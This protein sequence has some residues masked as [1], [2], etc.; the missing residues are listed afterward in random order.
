MAEEKI[1]QEEIL[2]DEQL[3]NISGGTYTEAEKDARTFA[4]AT[5]GIDCYLDESKT[6]PSIPKLKEAFETFGITLNYSVSGNNSYFFEGIKVSRDTAQNI[7]FATY[8]HQPFKVDKNG[9]MTY[10]K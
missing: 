7:I 1:F 5:F 3:E 8:R 4:G 9:K 10:I 2:S 6:I